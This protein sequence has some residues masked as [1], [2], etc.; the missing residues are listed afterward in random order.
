MTF[1]FYSDYRSYPCGPIFIV[2]KVGDRYRSFCSIQQYFIHV[3]LAERCLRLIKIFEEPE[4]R[5]PIQQELLLAQDKPEEFWTSEPQC[6]A[7]CPFPFPYLATCLMLGASFE[8]SE[9][10]LDHTKLFSTDQEFDKLQSSDAVTILDISEP[11]NVRYCFVRYNPYG[12]P[13]PT[14]TPLSAAS[15]LFD[16]FDGDGEEEEESEEDSDYEDSD[17]EESDNED[18]DDEDSDDDDS[19]HEASDHEAESDED[20]GSEEDGE[21]DAY[22]HE[23]VD[24]NDIPQTRSHR[25]P[26]EWARIIAKGFKGRQLMSVQSLNSAWPRKNWKGLVEAR[27]GPT[28]QALHSSSQVTSLRTLAFDKV[29]EMALTDPEFDMS[30]ITQLA[31]LLE[32]FLPRLRDSLYK[33]SV[34]LEPSPTSIRVIVQAFQDVPGFHLGGFQKFDSD[35]HLSVVA[36]L[37]EKTRLCTLDLSGSTKLN[38]EGLRR[39]LEITPSLQK[40]YLLDNPLL[41]LQSVLDVLHENR[42]NVPTLYHPDLFHIFLHHRA[43]WPIPAEYHIKFPTGASTKSP[44]IQILWVFTCASELDE[45]NCRSCGIHWDK[46]TAD[47]K[48]MGSYSDFS[49]YDSPGL[50]Y[51]RFSLKHGQISPSRLVTGMSQFAEF[52]LNNKS[53]TRY[54]YESYAQAVA[55][56]FAMAPSS[57]KG[58]RYQVG[59]VP[60]MLTIDPLSPMRI[61]DDNAPEHLFSTLI[62]G[63]WSL[64]VVHEHV[65]YKHFTMETDLPDLKQKWRYAFITL[66]SDSAPYSSKDTELVVAD[67]DTFLSEVA[68]DEAKELSEYWEQVQSELDGVEPCDKEI[69][70]ALWRGLFREKHCKSGS[71]SHH[72][73]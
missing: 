62:P 24:C 12:L 16:S 32:D 3:T 11:H 57:V 49:S 69:V 19:D 46:F 40:I 56:S 45:Y 28:N 7:C 39:I 23:E 48:A 20:S 70:Q 60:L 10:F 2:A 58:S 36:G 43:R 44:A 68:G 35:D 41:P 33:C 47:I 9:G 71:Y 42:L 13:V 21:V 30:W 1:P 51:G 63:D 18:S 27:D 26:V 61:T 37:Q 17:Y 55:T 15:F 65:Y 66:R 4:N 31:D 50:N 67:M 25:S 73:L 52:S 54:H 22:S 29:V 34:H 8:A 5:I 72:L 59:P 64:I 6:P 53:W 38:L 14:M